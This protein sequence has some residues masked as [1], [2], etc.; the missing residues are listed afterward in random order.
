[1]L[2]WYIVLTIFHNDQASPGLCKIV[3]MKFWCIVVL[4]SRGDWP[5]HARNQDLKVQPVC[6]YL[7]TSRIVFIHRLNNKGRM[8]GKCNISSM[9]TFVI[10]LYKPHMFGWGVARYIWLSDISLWWHHKIE[11]YIKH[12]TKVKADIPIRTWIVKCDIDMELFLIYF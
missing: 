1:M 12:I 9:R 7:F 3:R 11:L 2:H 4:Q 8:K 6:L 5:K 10:I